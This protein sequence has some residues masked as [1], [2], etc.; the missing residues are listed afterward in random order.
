ML[1]R[2]SP[3]PDEGTSRRDACSHERPRAPLA[4]ASPSTVP[5]T[6]P[7][8]T[9]QVPAIAKKKS[10]WDD[11]LQEAGGAPPMHLIGHVWLLFQTP[12]RFGLESRVASPSSALRRNIVKLLTGQHL[13]DVVTSFKNSTSHA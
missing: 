3:S 13:V 4:D 1:H 11:E 10:T 5:Y 12:P 8:R 2:C 6:P 9:R 7:L